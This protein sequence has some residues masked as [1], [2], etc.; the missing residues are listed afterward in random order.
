MIPSDNTFPNQQGGNSRGLSAREEREV[1]DGYRN[2]SQP[3]PYYP[4]YEVD[5]E[6]SEK[7]DVYKY[8]R[9]IL[10]YRWLIACMAVTTLLVAAVVTFLMTPIY[11]ATS[12][13]QID[14][15]TVNVVDVKG[16]QSEQDPFADDF[17]QTKYEL[18]ASRSLAERVV[19][20]LDLA[21][22]NTFQVESKGLT[23]NLYAMV[24]GSSK[25]DLPVI[26]V[27]SRNRRSVKA[28]VDGITIAPVRG[29]RI[30]RI[31]FDHPRADVAT[32]IA[33]GYAE[34]F[35]ADNLDRRYDATSYARKFLEERLQQLKG[36][37]EESEKQLVQ[38]AEQ[39]GIINLGDDKNL[40]ITDLE[41]INVKLAEAHSL[42]LK[43]E[44]LWK[45][46]K[47]KGGFGLK[48]ILDSPT[49]QENRKVRTALAAQYQ[50]KLAI[51][52][53]AFPDMVQLR[54]QIA[55]LDR[56]GGAEIQSIKSSIESTY[57]AAK[58][59]EESILAQLAQTKTDVVQQRN[60]NIDYTILKREV[61][62]NRTLYD[63]LLQRYKEIGVAGAVGNNNISIVDSAAFPRF[64]RTPNLS[65]NLILGLLAGLV[66]GLLAAF[67]LDYLDDS[68]KSPED[69]ER[70]IGLSVI[71]VVPRPA[72]GFEVEQ[73]LL[74]ARSGM[75]EAIRS[76][77]TG[78]QFATSEGLPK[79][80]LV[81]S[82]KP[83]E[84]KTT[85][86][87]ALAKSLASIGL[88]VLLIDG[89]LRNAS[90]HRKLN[91]S[92]ELGLSNYLTGHK[93]P[94]DVVQST[95][96]E[97][98]VVMASGPLPPNPAEL[99]SGPRLHSLLALGTQSFDIVVI[100]GPP[101]MGLADAPLL[102]SI[103][104]ATLLVV[105]AGETRRH[106]AKIALKRIQ[107][108]RGNVIGALLSKFDVKQAGY[109]YGYGYGDYDYHSYGIAKLPSRA[110]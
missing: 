19:N 80:L 58:Q 56:Q 4:Q 1:A 29:S 93:M 67:G 50:Q 46:A 86:S 27:E 65:R 35:I 73:E 26:D 59:E 39:K 30:V 53:P 107:F 97:G 47:T 82:S 11:R 24:F 8:L 66:L 55:E 85:T 90:V 15:E 102:S 89:D 83:S 63:G 103:A 64:P 68:F 110:A 49:I 106:T 79:T 21:D 28:L 44:L 92:N 78:L 3:Y 99:L 6:P 12:S 45:Q 62:T 42:R 7:F 32:K 18:L 38:Y 40:A 87:I 95:D 5:P 75:A 94:E 70:N 84:G 2:S 17:Y 69:I 60:S 33:N 98:L 43:S 54:N 36:K 48:E 14:R 81:T 101:I 61:D 91:C 108:A 72:I 88:N 13:I 96:T 104:R 100:D 37:L 51:F 77:R 105:A 76:L 109:G 16:V 34:V 10:K 31:S 23:D 20:T 41:A 57:L 25:E 71:G 74:N 9:T 52:K 22:D